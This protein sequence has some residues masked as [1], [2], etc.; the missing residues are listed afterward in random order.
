MLVTLTEVVENTTTTNLTDSTNTKKYTLREV[1]INPEY[2]VC[3]RE[4]AKMKQM[5]SE[6]FLPSELNNTHQF[7]RVY[8]D[9]GQSGIDIVVVGDRQ[10]VEEKIDRLRK[11]GNREL[12]NG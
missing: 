10:A 6:G 8:L 2:V 3:V 4:D 1:T 9:R 12:L 11:T 5:L 7:T